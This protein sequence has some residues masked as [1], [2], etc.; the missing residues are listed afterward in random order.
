MTFFQ[1]WDTIK[2][3][4]ITLNELVS[5]ILIF[6][7]MIIVVKIVRN[8]LRRVLDKTTLDSGLKSFIESTV[9]VLLW[10]VGIII[11]ADSLGIPVT[12]LVALVSVA[13]LALSLSIQNILSNLFSGITILLSR[14][15]KG[16]E[17]VEVCGKQGTVSSI[18]LIH[19]LI[20]TPDGKEIFVPNGKITDNEIINFSAEG[21]R[22]VDLKFGASYDNP[23]SQVRKAILEA[24]ENQPMIL[25][26]PMPFVAI[27]NYG[28]SAVEYICRV[29]VES[30]NYW[31]VYFGLN[32]AVRESFNESGVEI[33]YNHLNIHLIRDEDKKQITQ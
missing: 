1:E 4:T 21:K 22:R 13:G 16:G 8:L 29:W 11:I 7:L 26:D 24:I 14:P 28:E 3:G 27:E 18:G 25:H 31:D 15:F 23:T 32:E 10:L 5:A 12:S 19:T 9:K 6:I 2:I 17:F 20:I 30:Q 33:P